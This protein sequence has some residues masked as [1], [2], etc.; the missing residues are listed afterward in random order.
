MDIKKIDKLTGDTYWVRNNLLDIGHRDHSMLTSIRGGDYH[1]TAANDTISIPLDTPLGSDFKIGNVAFW[2]KGDTGAVLVNGLHLNIV[3]KTE[4]YTATAIDDTIIGDATGGA[5]T[6]T[7]PA[8]STVTGKIYNIKKIDVSANA[9]TIDG[10][11]A[12]TI[13]DSATQALSSQYDSLT[14]QSD[15]TEYWII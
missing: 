4:A 5:F 12:E 6:V 9:I 3:K 15:G 8:A 7:L 10:D 13:D 14:I 1:L 11:G 2:V